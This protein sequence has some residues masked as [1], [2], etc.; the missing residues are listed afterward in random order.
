MG[1]V[2][3]GYRVKKRPGGAPEGFDVGRAV[4]GEG[5]GGDGGRGGGLVR[6]SGGGFGLAAGH[7]EPGGYVG[8]GSTSRIYVLALGHDI[9][10]TLQSL[11]CAMLRAHCGNVSRTV[12]HLDPV[13][14]PLAAS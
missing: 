12:C 7:G 1:G 14:H 8:A 4:R 11:S 9:Y 2:G 6:G 5:R 3:G 10:S 13:Q